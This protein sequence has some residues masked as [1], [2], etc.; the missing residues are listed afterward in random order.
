MS[1]SFHFGLNGIGL[2]DT[3]Y[4]TAG[5]GVQSSGRCNEA[6]PRAEG[7][8][9]AGCKATRL[10]LGARHRI[11]GLKGYGPPVAKWR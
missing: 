6:G 4:R 11:A 10:H 5:S 2:Q 8:K 1:P 7:Y 3:G 9:A